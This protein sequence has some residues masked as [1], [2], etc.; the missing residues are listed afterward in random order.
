MS[1]LAKPNAAPARPLAPGDPVV[2]VA[3]NLA[4]VTRTDS[5]LR[6]CVVRRERDDE[7]VSHTHA[8]VQRREK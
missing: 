8:H 4:T 1:E 6:E 5:K 3:G 2:T 7:L